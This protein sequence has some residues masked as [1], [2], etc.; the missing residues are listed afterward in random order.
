MSFKF[1]DIHHKAE[2]RLVMLKGVICAVFGI[3]CLLATDERYLLLT[4]SLG[5]AA[6]LNGIL[7]LSSVW[8]SVRTALRHFRLLQYEG[9]ASVMIGVLLL[10]F[11]QT[12]ITVIMGILGTILI[13]M[14]VAQ[15]LLFFDWERFV[16]REWLLLASGALT[17][18]LGVILFK[19]PYAI[20][21]FVTILLGLFFLITGA[22]VVYFMYRTIAAPASADSTPVAVDKKADSYLIPGKSSKAVPLP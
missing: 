18:L 2:A 16:V 22:Y 1:I 21:S 19:N 10:C 6:L 5:I 11:P 15:L 13:L 8:Y 14:G 7:S 3:V 20:S 12:A 4:Y 17:I 9:V